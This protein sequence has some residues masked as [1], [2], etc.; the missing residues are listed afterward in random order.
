MPDPT[1]GLGSQPSSSGAG[2]G[3]RVMAAARTCRRSSCWLQ[4]CNLAK[5]TP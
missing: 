5:A 4:V 1:A 3:S 2:L